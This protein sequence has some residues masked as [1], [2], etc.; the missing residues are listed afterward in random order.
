MIVEL[1]CTYCGKKWQIQ[2]VNQAQIESS[3]CIKCGDS[4]LKI[5]DASKSKI[6]YYEGCPAFPDKLFDLYNQRSD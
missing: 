4:S 1:E 6:D 5:R 2:S 3:K